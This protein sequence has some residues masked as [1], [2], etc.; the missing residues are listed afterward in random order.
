MGVVDVL[1]IVLLVCAVLVLVG[2][3]WS[4]LGPRL[5]SEAWAG[6]SRARR[7]RRLKVVGGE[8]DDDFV[9]SVQRDLEDL[10]VIEENDDRQRR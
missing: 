7:K 10:P 6:R 4:R 2:A 1:A 5:G 3:E 8:R 9:A